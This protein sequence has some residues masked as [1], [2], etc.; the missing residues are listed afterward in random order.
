MSAT[1]RYRIKPKSPTAHLFEVELTLDEPN[2]EGQEFTLPNWIPGSYMIRDYARHIVSLRAESD[3]LN[4][5]LEKL[6]KSHWRA[7]P[8]TRALTVI[9]EIY[10]FDDSVRGSHLDT[11]HAYFNGVCGFLEPVGQSDHACE[12]DIE[13]PDSPWGKNWR[14]ATSM[15][16]AGAPQYGFGRYR[17]AN[18]AELIDHPVE[19]GELSIGEFDV[20]GIPHAIAIRGEQSADMARLCHDLERICGTHMELLG[21]PADLDR[22]LFL[23]HAPVKG[24]GGI[25]HRWSSSNVISRSHLP[26]KGDEGVSDDYRELLGLLS[27]EYFHLW[28]VKRMKPAAF[29]PYALDQESYTGLLWVFEGIT[30]YYDDLALLRSGLIDAK[31]YLELVGR[32]M[33]RVQRGQG[34]RRQTVEESSFDA[35]TKFY[36]QDANGPNAVVSYYA[37]GALIA[38]ALDLKLREE[39]NGELT[40]DGVMAECW[41]RFGE[42]GVGMPERGLE[43][44]LSELGGMAFEDFFDAAV[45]GTHD[46]PLDA[47][48]EGHGIKVHYRAADGAGDK[49]GRA[50]STPLDVWFGATQKTGNGGPVVAT[51]TNDSP[52]EKAGLQPGDEIL[53][54][55]RLRLRSGNL[56]SLLR[57]YRVRDK[58][59][60]VISRG[61]VVDRLTVVFE[62]APRDTVYLELIEE[63]GDEARQRRLDFLYA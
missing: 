63:P 55:D 9:A 2:P 39:T 16:S 13:A 42:T 54:V 5:P 45:R 50:S 34:R 51:V 47:L 57:R 14:V 43:T 62:E 52:A 29:T 6:S 61:D 28:N 56:D 60:L 23:L 40:L 49:G 15:E 20:K 11:S 1:I 35:W 18:Y 44:V 31:S 19:I 38:L 48:L 12:L 24:Y 33:T 4:V 37:K 10:A 25:E 36:K 32:V 41:A 27:H 58:A 26:R 22:Y 53:A 30:S 21:A 7:A 59:E 46:L 17:A 3:G 8:V